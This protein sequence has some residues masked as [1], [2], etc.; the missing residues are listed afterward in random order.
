[1]S[2][3]NFLLL[4]LLAALWGGSFLFMRVAAPVLGPSLLIELRVLLAGF[5]L[6]VY[7]Y[8]IR[9]AP[10]FRKK[11]PRYILLGAINAGLPFTLIASSELH[12]SA[13]VSSILNATTP[14]FAV[15]IARLWLKEKFT[16]KKIAGIFLGIA[17]VSV[18]V[19]GFHGGGSSLLILSVLFSLLAAL[20]YGIGGVYAKSHFA[21]EPALTLGIGQQLGA[22]LVLLPFS[23]PDSGHLQALASPVLLFSVLALAILCTSIGYL[24]YFYLIRQVGPTQTLSVTLL[25]S[26]YGVIWGALFL[27]E[28]LSLSTFAGMLI[29]LSSMVLITGIKITAPLNRIMRRAG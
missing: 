3:K 21:G 7:T 9:Q 18:L 26:V 6:L 1:M 12:L 25:V 13:S 14:L 27:R 5:F 16:F 29:I 24:I 4:N 8:A 28:H 17:G 20:C 11:W 23:L 2:L 22:A 15:I 19:G 10:D